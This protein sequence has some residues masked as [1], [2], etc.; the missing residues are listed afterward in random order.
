MKFVFLPGQ[1]LSDEHRV[2]RGWSRVSLNHP[3]YCCFI[4]HPNGEDDN[5]MPDLWALGLEPI[6]KSVAYEIEPKDRD[7]DCNP[8]VRGQM[9]RD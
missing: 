1:S 6:L 2:N 9:G 3:P 5:V 4:Y 7:H 8:R